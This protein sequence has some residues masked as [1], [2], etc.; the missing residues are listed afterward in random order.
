MPICPRCGHGVS[1]VPIAV[2]GGTVTCCRNRPPRN[3]TAGRTE[4]HCSQ[5]VAIVPAPGGVVLVLALTA[6]EARTLTYGQLLDIPT[7]EIAACHTAL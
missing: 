7:A 1:G 6:S 2:T 5:H 3:P 4:N